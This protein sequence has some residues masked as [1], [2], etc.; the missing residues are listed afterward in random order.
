VSVGASALRRAAEGDPLVAIGASAGGPAV[1]AALLSRLPKDFGAAIVIVQHMDAHMAAGMVDWLG[2]N[3][4]LSVRL[5]Q[6]GDRP[7]PGTALVAG[8][9]DHLVLKTPTRLGYTPDPREY[10]YRPSVDVFFHSVGRLWRGG[11]TGVLL[12]GMGR[13]GAAGLKALRDGGCHTIAQDE[14]SSAV[15]GMPKAAARLNAAVDILPIE[16]I[17]SRLVSL[18]AH[19]TARHIRL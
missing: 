10:V 12:T 4:A 7:R 1:L 11:I 15:Y 19:Q 16:K 14:E 18:V 2:Q 13:D 3:S 9:S 5:A 8:T 6:E 17:T